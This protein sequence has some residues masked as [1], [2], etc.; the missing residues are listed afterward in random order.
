[1]II[2]YGTNIRDVAQ[3]LRKRI[4]NEVDKMAGRKVIEVNIRV[5]D[6][7]LPGEQKKEEPEE[8][9]PPPRVR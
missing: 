2:D 9:S 1:V 4:A 7:N 3:E 6:I 8:T 5:V